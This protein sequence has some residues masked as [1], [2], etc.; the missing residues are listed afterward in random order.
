MRSGRL[1]SMLMLLQ[2]HGRVS[3]RRLAEETGVSVR[4]A[5]RDMDELSASGVPVR[6]LRGSAGGFELLEGWRTRLTGLTAT[7]AQ[8]MLMAGA[9][10]PAAQLG[11]GDAAGSAQV[12]LL[13]AL[14]EAWQA[15][16]R[17]VATRFHLDTVGWYRREQR[18]D[19]LPHVA[20]AVWQDRRLAI[21]YE[22]WKGVVER[23]VDP[24]GLVVKAG[25]W[26]L[27]A[28][29]GR[30]G[31]RTYRV[32]N[33]LGIAP[34]SGTTRRPRGFDLARFWAQSIERFEAGLYRGSAT[35]RA[36]AA[37]LKKLRHASA[38]LAQAVDA[39]VATE[40]WTTLRIPIESLEHATAELLRLG[41]DCEALA[42]A[43]LRARM[44][45]HVAGLAGMYAS[46]KPKPTRQ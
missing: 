10:G 33:I 24:L 41:T 6:A 9:P 7:E 29:A 17:R 11:L 15:D 22:S 13:A 18:L 30:G 43:E 19:N 8:A 37:G 45:E 42:P 21:R 28:L 23:R 12:K 36:N 31:P 27:V 16:A 14:P 25:E 1:L 3:A 32:A 4:T 35:V 26:Y 39:T 46:R 34:A 44:A 20:Q 5:L 38:A 40:P 2:A